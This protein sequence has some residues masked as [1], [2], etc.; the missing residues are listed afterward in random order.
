MLVNMTFKY[1]ISL[2]KKLT[3]KYGIFNSSFTWS[4]SFLSRVSVFHYALKHA[5]DMPRLY[6]SSS[7]PPSVEKVNTYFLLTKYVLPLL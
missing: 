1:G 7:D 3:K 6:R 5:H 2:Y 4:F